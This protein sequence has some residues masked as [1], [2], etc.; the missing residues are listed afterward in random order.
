MHEYL[1][2]SVFLVPIQDDRLGKVLK[3]SKICCTLVILFSYTAL[4]LFFQLSRVI[5][6]GKFELL[7][8]LFINWLIWVVPDLKRGVSQ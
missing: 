8:Y 4:I 2:Y 6:G 5:R 3:T 7:T 1:T